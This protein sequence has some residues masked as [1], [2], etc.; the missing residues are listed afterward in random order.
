MGIIA[1]KTQKS[2]QKNVSL[3]IPVIIF[4]NPY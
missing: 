1:Q 3:I 4:L 2:Q